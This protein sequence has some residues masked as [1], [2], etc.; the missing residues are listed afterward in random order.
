MTHTPTLDE[1]AQEYATD[2]A[3][4]I[5]R[6]INRA[7]PGDATRWPG[8][9]QRE[10]AHRLRCAIA[11]KLIGPHNEQLRDLIDAYRNADDDV[12]RHIRG[13]GIDPTDAIEAFESQAENVVA[14][15][16]DQLE[17]AAA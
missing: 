3:D 16:R 2:F 4:C 15:L 8:S 1:L 17:E 11:A 14:W 12:T 9:A 7:H 10:T 13:M 5:D 6:Y